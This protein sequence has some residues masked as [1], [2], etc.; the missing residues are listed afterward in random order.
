MV[1]VNKYLYYNS[2]VFINNTW[3]LAREHKKIRKFMKTKW[4]FYVKNIIHRFY[5]KN[6]YRVKETIKA[7]NLINYRNDIRRAIF[8]DPG[9]ITR[10]D[11]FDSPPFW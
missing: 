2:P 3:L 8:T 5:L 6:L 9:S 11:Q 10:P 4:N 1:Y 7:S